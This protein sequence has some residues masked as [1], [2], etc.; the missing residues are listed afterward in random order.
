M[1]ARCVVPPPSRMDNPDAVR[2]PITLLLS[3][4]D[5]LVL[6]ECLARAEF[7]DLLAGL[8]PPERLVLARLEGQLERTLVAPLDPH[9]DE[10]LAAARQRVAPQ[11]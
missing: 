2:E 8:L 9:Y 7:A 6:F 1:A 11:T 4:D 5:A 10:V 3:A